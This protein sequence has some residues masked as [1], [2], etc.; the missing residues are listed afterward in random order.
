MAIQDAPDG[1]QWVQVISVVIDKPVP[2]ESATEHVIDTYD[3]KS[4]NSAVYQT[5]VSRTV[6]GGRIGILDSIEL[7]CDNYDVAQFRITVK[8]VK[9][10]DGDKLPESFTKDFPSL[11]LAPGE[12]WK[13]EVKS[14]G[15]TTI[16]AYC[17]VSYKEVG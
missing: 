2:E 9:I 6:P 15:A 16:A 7:S 5:I 17:D 3:K 14:D 13:V 11:H 10:L 4:T 8:G 1:T 12:S